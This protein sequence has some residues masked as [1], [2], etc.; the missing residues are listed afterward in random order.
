MNTKGFELAMSTLVAL[1]LGV[2]VLGVLIFGFSYGWDAFWGDIKGFLGGRD[3]VQQVLDSCERACLQEQQY[4][5]CTLLRTVIVNEK[6]I[7]PSPTCQN[8]SILYD[9]S[10]SKV[11][12]R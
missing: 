7:K 5:Y 1:I 2:L 6:Q 11:S 3:N 8:L 10:C 12:C 9:F 4:D